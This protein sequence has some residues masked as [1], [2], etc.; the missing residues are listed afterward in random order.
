M[1]NR[2]QELTE[3]IYNEGVV[4]VKNDA[5]KIIQ[6]A[7]NEASELIKSAKKQRDEIL[8]QAKS[9]AAEVKK[10]AGAEMQL[11]ARQ[12]ISNL[13]QKV[14]T[15]IVTAQI[16]PPLNEAFTDTGFVKEIILT[17]VQNWNQQNPEGPD[18]QIGVPENKKDQFL[19]LLEERA[20]K[21]LNKGVEIQTDAKLKT[22]F[23]IGPKDG[24]Y[25]IRFSGDDFENYFKGY[26]KEKTRKL[27]FGEDEK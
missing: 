7:K 23:S 9:E 15:L 14:E 13:K 6:D 2:I 26:F 10:N 11:A 5:E 24:S 8:E 20:I 21:T 3:K 12:F 25:F 18:L 1:T 4:K 27:L 16:E 17:L 19:S 22:G